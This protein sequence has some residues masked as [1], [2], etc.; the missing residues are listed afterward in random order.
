MT[1]AAVEELCC[2]TCASPLRARGVLDVFANGLECR[3]G[4]RFLTW[5]RRAL[6]EDSA[7]AGDVAVPDSLDDLGIINHW[8][9]VRSA[10][11][12][13]NEQLAEILARIHSIYSGN[14]HVQSENA[15]L[16]CPRC[17]GCLEESEPLG[18]K[19]GLVCSSGHS[20]YER[21]GRLMGTSPD[22]P[23]VLARELDD[24][25]LHTLVMRWL[26]GSAELESN[27]HP[28][29]RA[30]LGRFKA[31]QSP[32]TPASDCPGGRL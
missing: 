22:G 4:H 23:V 26:R 12:R 20:W 31:S 7:R 5:K 28:S 25:T 16:M 30:I 9:G 32:S 11:S 2:P 29:I 17:G 8:L 10:R 14:R 1:S 15:F 27:L 3:E 18:W 6:A 21:G 19:R 24:E 13:L